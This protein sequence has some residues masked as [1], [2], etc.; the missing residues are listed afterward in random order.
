MTQFA[1]VDFKDK[2]MAQ[3]CLVGGPMQEE[4]R[5]LYE[6][7]VYLN[8]HMPRFHHDNMIKAQKKYK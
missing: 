3:R 5:Q 2:V 8:M 4:L 6:G 7:E 1:F